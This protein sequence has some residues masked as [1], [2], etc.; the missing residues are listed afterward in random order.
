M[1]P[2]MKVT[3]DLS[4]F[5]IVP[6]DKS[7]EL[8]FLSIATFFKKQNFPLGFFCLYRV[9]IMCPIATIDKSAS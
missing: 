1:Q 7:T 4:F 5:S 2:Q 3:G 6:I 8:S 9:F